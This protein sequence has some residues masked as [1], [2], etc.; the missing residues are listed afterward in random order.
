M[1]QKQK[2]IR[3]GY[4]PVGNGTI[5]SPPDCGSSVIRP[6]KKITLDS[7]N[8]ERAEN[9]K[10]T[11][12]RLQFVLWPERYKNLRKTNYFTFY[13]SYLDTREL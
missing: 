3:G 4:Q 7:F 10:K 5:P 11:K 6:R 9:N 8:Y 2:R 13:K 1:K 12:L